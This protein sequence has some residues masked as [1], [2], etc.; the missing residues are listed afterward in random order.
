MLLPRPNLALLLALLP[1]AF[2]LAQETTFTK[3]TVGDIVNNGGNSNGCAWGDYDNDGD[4]DLFV[5]N[6]A[7]NNF[8]YQN[9]GNGAFTKITSGPI[10]YDGGNSIG[11]SWGDYDNDGDLDLFVANSNNQNNFLY[12]NNLTGNQW[13]NIRLIGTLSNTS[14]IGARVRVKARVLETPVWQMQEVSGQ[15]GYAGQ[16]S[17]NAEFGLKKAAIIDSIQIHWPSGAVNGY[18]N[19]KVNQFLTLRENNRP[20]TTRSIADINLSQVGSDSVLDLNAAPALFKDLDHDTLTYSVASSNS[21]IATASLSGGV[22]TVALVSDKFSGRARI[23]ISADDGRVDDGRGNTEETSFEI[24]RPP[25]I[26]KTIPNQILTPQDSSRFVADFSEVFLDPD[27]DVLAHSLSNSDSTVAIVTIRGTS[28]VA[29][30][31]DSL[32][33]ATI[34]LFANDRRGGTLATTFK[35]IKNAPPGLAGSGIADQVLILAGQPFVQ[36]LYEIFTDAEGDS[37]NFA[38]RSNSNPDTVLAVVQSN[39][40]TVVPLAIGS[41]Q[42]T[43]T[44]NDGKG[45]EISSSFQVQVVRSQAPQIAHISLSEPQPLSTAITVTA[46]IT[47]DD[48]TKPA[49]LLNYR[50]AGRPIFEKRAM[51]IEKIADT[52]F[53]VTG[54]IPREAVTSQGVEYKIEATDIH[55]VPASNPS[56]GF[57]SVR[58]RVAAGV[59]HTLAGGEGEESYHLFSVPLDLDNKSPNAVFRELGAYDVLKWRFYELATDTVSGTYSYREYPNTDSLRPGKAYW[60]I[61][62]KS[63]VINTGAGTTI[64]TSERYPIALQ[65]GWNFVGNPFNFEA[66]AEDTAVNDSALSFYAYAFGKDWSD[67]QPDSA[68]VLQ[69]FSGYAVYA[70]TLR[71]LFINPHRFGGGTL[72]AK[73]ELNEAER[74]WSIRIVAQCQRAQDRN[75]VAVIAKQASQAWDGGDHP[76]PPVIGEYISVYFPHRE[77]NTLA[78]TYCIDARPEPS[79]GEVWDFEVKT[80]IRDKVNLSFEG[81]AGVPSEFEVWF[82]DEALQITQN[83]REQGQYAVA[84]TEHP[85]AL[86]LVVGKREFISQQL[87]EINLVPATYELSQNFPNPFNPVT[88]IRYGLPQAE[89]VSLKIYNLLGEEVVTLVNDEQKAAGYHVAI[90]E[91][92]DKRGV[93][94]VS[95]LYAYLMRAGRFVMAKKLVLIK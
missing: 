16:N 45:G 3:I 94:V 29:S 64:R 57:Y 25:F 46:T 26:L 83:L 44:A 78:K 88:T 60:L 56:K 89:R 72:L 77:W 74:L 68:I 32:G 51:Q 81:I 9:N 27:G 35:V 41:A 84:G 65:R 66:I 90:W 82:V 5:A 7:Q 69:P 59:S 61:T 20:R 14:A 91:G 2:V 39:T 19:V 75:N 13:I 17:L 58:V 79:E 93:Y 95:G 86:K 4:L 33:E 80:N 43:V 47:D 23:I 6:Y 76:E 53:S 40:L 30:V 92:K 28:I 12:Q 42:I 18:A 63:S 31:R 52:T 15:T 11:S 38:L 73:Q 48:S 67:P 70:P 50:I 24:N 37:L 21:Q 36:P 1:S 71:T 22:L 87:A 85:K 10:V 55:A 34:T 8:L 49:T 62:R 54:E